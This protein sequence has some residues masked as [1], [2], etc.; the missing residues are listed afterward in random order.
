MLSPNRSEPPTQKTDLLKAALN[1]VGR[2]FSV[3]GS[4]L[5]GPL[6]QEHPL[7]T[8]AQDAHLAAKH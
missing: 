6:W 3:T 5:E 8:E 4:P 1:F 2:D 7:V